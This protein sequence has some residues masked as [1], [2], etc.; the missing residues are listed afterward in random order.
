MFASPS[1]VCL[2]LRRHRLSLGAENPSF[3]TGRCSNL[4][5][6]AVA[7]A[8]TTTPDDYTML[9]EEQRA[10]IL[11]PTERPSERFTGE[12]LAR[13]RQTVRVQTRRP[14]LARR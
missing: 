4:A 8:V 12:L 10:H 9:A 5:G 1:V 2:G 11:R 14:S 13:D 7:R 6:T 3:A